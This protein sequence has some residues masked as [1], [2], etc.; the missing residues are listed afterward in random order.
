MCQPIFGNQEYSTAI[1]RKH[2][3]LTWKCCWDKYNS[4]RVGS[5][6]S[7]KGLCNSWAGGYVLCVRRANSFS[8]VNISPG[9][10]PS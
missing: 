5:T 2:M 4:R 6:P 9:F 1:N 3:T 7:G 10:R 8:T